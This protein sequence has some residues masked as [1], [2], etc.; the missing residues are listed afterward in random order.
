MDSLDEQ[1]SQTESQHVPKQV[2]RPA[3]AQV[4]AVFQPRCEMYDPWNKTEDVVDH[5][6]SCLRSTPQ[7]SN[8]LSTF[9]RPMLLKV[10]E[11]LNDPWNSFDTF[12]EPTDSK[13]SIPDFGHD[14]GPKQTGPSTHDKPMPQ[15][16][17]RLKLGEDPNDLWN[18]FEQFCGCTNFEHRELQSEFH[19]SLHTKVDPRN[20]L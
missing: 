7:P 11:D 9:G 3:P 6:Q 20:A 18:T 13:Q 17:V 15:T 8:G 16:P 19:N 1:K 4:F 12:E 10:G 5:D 2:F 14:I